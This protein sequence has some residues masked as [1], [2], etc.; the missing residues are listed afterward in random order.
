[1]FVP[2]LLV[3]EVW[4]SIGWDSIVYLAAITSIDP[5]LYE[6]AEIDGA[7]RIS[8]I[9]HITLPSLMPVIAILFLLRIGNI[10]DAPESFGARSMIHVSALSACS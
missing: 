7:G 9:R 6:A 4:K 3:S 8:R 10:L 2:I 1:M 5:Q